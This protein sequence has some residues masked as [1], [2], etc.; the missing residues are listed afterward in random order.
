M[1]TRYRLLLRGLATNWV[2]TLGI[3][4]TT[5]AFLL[6]VAF[7]ALQL[8]GAV[9]NAYVGLVSYMVLPAVFVAGLCLIPVGWW[10][11]RRTTGHTTRDLLS[12][13]F[14]PDFVHPG[15]IGSRLL[16]WIGAL[17]LLN[18][19]FLGAGTARMLSFMNEPRFCGTACHSVMSPEWTTYQ[20]SPHAHVRCVDCHVGEG[21][22][23]QL[24]AKLNGLWQLVSVTFDLH[25]RPI[26][27]PV[28]N[29]RPARET[30][31]RCHW[32]AKLYGDRIRVRRHFAADS[33]S[34]PRYTTLALKVGSGRGEQRGEI[35]WHVAP[36]NEVRYAP[37]DEARSAMRW[38]E[39]R[40]P[41][42]SIRRFDSRKLADTADQGLPV[43]SLDCVDCHNRATHI[44]EDPEQAVDA[45][46]ADGRLDRALPFAKQQALSALTGGYA[47][48]AAAEEGITRAIR[49]WYGHSYP[50]EAAIRQESIDRTV[51]TLLATWRRNRH[52]RMRIDWGA[53]PDHLGHRGG[54]GGCFR[55]H[56]TDLVDRDG[57]TI[58][59]DCT[60]CHSILAEDSPEPFSF[61]AEPKEGDPNRR[62]HEHLRDE[63]MGRR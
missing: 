37:A 12:E 27:T 31:E 45:R 24:D 3:A 49:G 10:L 57:R 17:T 41:D 6:F 4:L 23:A 20:A 54:H 59:D 60:L 36:D 58:S 42:G 15:V 30:C 34:T 61:L 50:R 55:C 48:E 21:P 22:E 25:E 39:V 5:A 8:L 44:Y 29:L 56:G 7:E 1:L 38:V 62:R 53:Y 46:L 16:L 63:F 40:Q 43:R 32:P 18:L 52:P 35:H 47:D 13:R 14:D 2:G 19:L 28:H 26:P 51:D 33:D 9:A 11:Y